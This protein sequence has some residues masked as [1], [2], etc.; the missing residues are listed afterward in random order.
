MTGL[1]RAVAT[2]EVLVCCGA[3]G[4]G[5]TTTAAALAIRAATELPARVLVLTIDPARR[6]ADAMGLDAI[7]NTEVE[8]SGLSELGGG[9]ARGELW[10]AMLD[11]TASWD[12][13]VRAHAPDA[14][15][16]E[17]ILANSLYRN[18]TSRLVHSHDYV[19][20]ERLHELRR[21]GRYDLIVVD[22]PP[23]RHALDFLEAPERMVEFFTSPLQR[24]LMAPAASRF[25]GLAA[26][27]FAAVADRLLG[28]TFVRDIAEFF[29]LF[30]TLAAGIAR[31]AAE[32]ERDLVGPSTGYVVVTTPEPIPTAEASALLA[33]LNRRRVSVVGLIANRVHPL[34][35][36]DRR[37]SGAARKM[38]SP[39]EAA[40]LADI[41]ANGPGT[42]KGRA[43]K[44][45]RD[46][47][48]AVVQA[49]GRAFL[50]RRAAAAAEQTVLDEL[51]TVGAPP[52]V[53][54]PWLG[55]DLTNLD[56]LARVASHLW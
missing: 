44:A 46:R 31:R 53:R 21:S 18:L 23:S 25:G 4:V 48:A 34:E 16:A 7:G 42:A 55:T 8:V 11:A 22:T 50:D 47:Q 27:S 14:R 41:V 19:A 56:G 30:N 52:V 26:R 36:L 10:A 40:S 24:W 6:L 43:A 33:E 28:S 5:K 9:E 38:A 54:V 39:A 3:G 45:H 2:R 13:L 32:V 12:D 51:P 17:A 35:L 37:A 15:T 29:S 1:D 20:V 49:S